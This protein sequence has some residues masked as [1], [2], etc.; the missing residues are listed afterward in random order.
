MRRI[1]FA[2][3]MLAALFC[4]SSQASPILSGTFNIAGNITVENA[5]SLGCP[6]A[7]Q[8]ITW[9]DPPALLANKADISGTGLTGVFASLQPGFS[10]NDMAN[11][12]DLR[13]PPQT[14]GGTG[15]SPAVLFMSFNEPGV[16]TTLLGNF[17]ASGIYTATACT[18]A[19]LVGQQCTPT[20]S[21]FNF[22]NNPNPGNPP[23]ATA[24]WVLAGVTNDGLSTWTAN[25]TAQF[26]V[27][28]QTVL[29]NLASS[30]FVNNTYSATV[31]VTPNAGVP[32]AGTMSLLGL[33]LV[34]VSTLARRKA[35]KV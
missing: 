16:T 25:F 3:L 6:A 35:R 1:L 31:T 17:I 19:P 22:V 18:A 9:S 30:G 12:F 24:T 15:Y 28:F 26:G 13:N 10:G 27:P 11:I 32:E 7:T 8:C 29:G 5:G 2:T 21:L 14:V 23:Q 34:L 4:A 20:G 33:G